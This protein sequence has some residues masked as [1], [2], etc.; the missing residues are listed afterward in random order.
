MKRGKNKRSMRP[1]DKRSKNLLLLVIP[2]IFILDRFIKLAAKDSCLGSFCIQRA[3]NDGA[4]FGIFS[5]QTTF[6]VIVSVLVL[7]LIISIYKKSTN[8]VKFALVFIAAGTISNLYDRVIYGYVIDVLSI[9]GSSSFNIADL[10]NVIGALI[11]IKV[12]V[13][14]GLKKRK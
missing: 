3:V 4:A 11:L 5:G 14:D 12:L 1:K 6:L 8:D 10:S 2:L 9:F 13:I 7:F